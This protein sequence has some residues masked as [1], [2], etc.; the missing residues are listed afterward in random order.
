MLLSP[1]A[2]AAWTLPG[3][4]AFDETAAGLFIS[5][6]PLPKGQRPLQLYQDNQCWQPPRR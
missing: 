1:A 4:P 6:A 5:Q 3:F 2:L